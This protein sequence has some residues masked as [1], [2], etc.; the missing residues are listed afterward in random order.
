MLIQTE[1]ITKKKGERMRT[2]KEIDTK[3]DKEAI[4][5]EEARLARKKLEDD[6][7]NKTNRKYTREE[8]GEIITKALKEDT[9]L[10]ILNKSALDK[11]IS[12]ATDEGE[13]ALYKQIMSRT[14]YLKKQHEQNFMMTQIK[15]VPDENLGGMSL[16]A[17][18]QL[19]KDQLEVKKAQHKA[20]AC[21]IGLLTGVA[22]GTPVGLQAAGIISI[23]A[24][25]KTV[26]AMK[27]FLPLALSNPIGLGITA[28]LLAGAIFGL[29]SYLAYRKFSQPASSSINNIVHNDGNYE[30]LDDSDDNLSVLTNTIY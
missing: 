5:A 2:T 15:Y 7:V 17:S 25:A 4:K 28:G 3:D 23:P 21:K 20:N 16:A 27:L 9:G 30:A 10:H 18:I 22:V 29:V 1:K 6:A 8:G 11:L 14:E 24:V 26:A 19:K 12:D 13:R